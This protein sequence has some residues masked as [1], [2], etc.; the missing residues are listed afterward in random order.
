MNEHLKLVR[1]LNDSFSF[2]QAEHGANA[3]LSDMDIIAHQALLLGKGSVAFKAIKRGVMADILAA[4]VDLA[5]CALG[6]IAMRGADVAEHPVSWHHEKSVL[7]L[8]QLLSDKI[9]H[10]STGSADDYSEVYCL[11]VALASGFL[12]ADFD[13]AFKKVH[14]NYLANRKVSGKFFC[15]T[16]EEIRKTPDLSDCL[17]E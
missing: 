11:C 1:A 10:C 13:K 4:L 6:A 16:L 15:E 5:Y 9:S 7:P 8:V 17:Y 14:D 3:H 12:N 2:P